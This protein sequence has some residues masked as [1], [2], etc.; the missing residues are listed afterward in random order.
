MTKGMTR[1]GLLALLCQNRR[2]KFQQRG[3][4]L[5][6]APTTKRFRSSRDAFA[7][8]IVRPCESMADTEPQLHPALLRLSAMIPNPSRKA[9]SRL[10]FLAEFLESGIGTQRVPERIELKKGRRNGRRAVIPTTV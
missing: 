6:G 5:I 2:F 8:Q 3:Q 7:I 9:D 4:L 10:L 1:Q